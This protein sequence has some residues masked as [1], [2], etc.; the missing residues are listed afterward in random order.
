MEERK[1]PGL[2]ANSLKLIAIVA[3][4]IDHLAWAFVPSASLLGQVMHIIGRTT[5]P[6]MCYFIAEGYY[7]TKNIKKYVARLTI[8]AVISHFAFIYYEHGTLPF[9]MQ[10]GHVNFNMQTSVIYT[11]L[12]GLL[13]LIVWNSKKLNKPLRDIIIV[14]IC[15]FSL[16]G[17]WAFMA[18]LWILFF[19]IYRGNYKKQMISFSIVAIFAWFLPNLFQIFFLEGVWWRQLF[20]IGVYLAIPIITHYNGTLG[21]NKNMKWLFYTFYPLHLAILGLIRWVIIK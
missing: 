21:K 7:H 13:T 6:I 12:L 11:L 8:F 4:L 17:D 15:I 5:A 16:I 18:V 9:E 1:I 19:G 3:M 2:S 14:I 20:Q 10:N